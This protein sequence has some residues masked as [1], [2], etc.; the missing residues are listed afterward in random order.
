MLNDAGY[1]FEYVEALKKIGERDIVDFVELNDFDIQ[2]LR[3]K[4]GKTLEADTLEEIPT[5][6]M[7]F[8]QFHNIPPPEKKAEMDEKEMGGNDMYS[9]QK[10]SSYDAFH[11]NTVDEKD[12][13]AIYQNRNIQFDDAPLPPNWDRAFDNLGRMYYINHKSKI[14]QWMVCFFIIKCIC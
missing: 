13:D 8:V 7:R 2:T 9:R 5:H 3:D 6:F 10:S 11:P 14:T 4:S 12:S 1:R